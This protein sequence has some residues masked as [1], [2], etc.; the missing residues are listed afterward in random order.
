MILYDG[1]PREQVNFEEEFIRELRNL[2]ENISIIEDKRNN[3]KF[4]YEYWALK[5]S[6]ANKDLSVGKVIMS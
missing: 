3:Q 4:N 5:L 1:V 6:R 2:K